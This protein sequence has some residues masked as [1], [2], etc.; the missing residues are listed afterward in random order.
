M[1]NNPVNLAFRF[2]LEITA[3]VSIGYWG[4]RQA[5]GAPGYALAGGAP[6]LAAVVWG[7]LRVPG[8]ASAS[9]EAPVAVP[10]IVRL[11]I[12]VA[13]FGFAVWGLLSEGATALGWAFGAAVLLHYLV[14]YDRIGWLLRQ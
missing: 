7:I 1:S 10:G 6:L 12:E 13:L 5:S 9:G 11:G 14:S 4:W 3:L 8:D 2:L